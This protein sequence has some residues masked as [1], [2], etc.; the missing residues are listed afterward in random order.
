MTLF[1]VQRE[2]PSLHRRAVSQNITGKE[3]AKIQRTHECVCLQEKELQESIDAYKQEQGVAELENNIQ[4]EEI[5]D[6]RKQL[7]EASETCKKL[8]TDSECEIDETRNSERAKN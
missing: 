7:K 3:L 6:L 1:C 2:R 5:E 4:V 8:E